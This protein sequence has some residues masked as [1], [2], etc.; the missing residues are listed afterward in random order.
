[1]TVRSADGSAGHEVRVDAADAAHACDLAALDLRGS[2]VGG[3]T[4][5]PPGGGE[6]FS[7]ERE[8]QMTGEGQAS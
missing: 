1:V 2:G 7:A 3:P 6:P 4:P 5:V 8:A